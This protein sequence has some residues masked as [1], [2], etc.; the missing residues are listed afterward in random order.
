MFDEVGVFRTEE[1][2]ARA[3][4]GLQ[5]LRR[6]FTDIRVGDS[7]KAY[8]TALL[9]AWELGNLLDLALVT[10]QAALARK[11]S[12]GAHARDDYPQRDDQ[13]WLKHSLAWMDERGAVRLAYKPVNITHYTPKERT[14]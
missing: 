2:L 14:Y 7:G 3:V 10:A 9:N 8:N 5:D 11:E 1:G 12:R 4:A 6:R 13:N